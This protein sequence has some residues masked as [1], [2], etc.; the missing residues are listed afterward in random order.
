MTVVSEQ[1]RNWMSPVWDARSSLE[2]LRDHLSVVLVSLEDIGDPALVSRLS[3]SRSALE[4][5]CVELAT[6]TLALA[7]VG[8]TSS[9]KST[10]INA[11]LGTRLAPMNVDEMSAGMLRIEH[12]ER[13]SLAATPG[14]P[15]LEF[16]RDPKAIYHRLYEEMISHIERREAKQSVTP[17]SFVVTGPLFPMNPKH[18]FAHRLSGDV[19]LRVFDLPGLRTINDEEN[20]RVIKGQIRRAFAVVV[21]NMIQLFA[22]EQREQILDELRETVRDLGNDTSTI[23]FVA[24]QADRLTHG[25]LENQSLADRLNIEAANIAEKLD[26]NPGSVELL[27]FSALNYY[28]AA[29]L[30]R[31][32]DAGNDAAARQL[33]EPFVRDFNF[34]YARMSLDDAE[35]KELRALVREVEDDL[36][37]SSS[38]TSLAD[39]NRLATLSL[40]A[41]G[42]ARFWYELCLRIAQNGVELI[43]YPTANIPLKQ[44]SSSLRDAIQYAKTRQST[45]R[46]E[47]EATRQQMNTLSET[48]SRRLGEH[49]ASLKSGLDRLLGLLKLVSNDNISRG[50]IYDVLSELGISEETYEYLAKARNLLLNLRV[51]L[52]SMLLEPLLD[53]LKKK[54]KLGDL[55]SRLL[56]AG[57]SNELVS[58]VIDAYETVK[59]VGYPEY[60]EHGMEFR[61]ETGVQDPEIEKVRRIR[62]SLAALFLALRKAMTQFSERHLRRESDLVA[63][64]IAGWLSTQGS[65]VWAQVLSDLSG[66]VSVDLPSE[67]QCTVPGGSVIEVPEQVITI[68]SVGLDSEETVQEHAGTT[69]EDPEASCFKGKEVEVFKD[70]TYTTYRIPNAESMVSD[71]DQGVR[72]ASADFWDRF[73]NW[74]TGTVDAMGNDMEAEV[75]NYAE[76]VKRAV[77]A[78][79]REL[80][81]ETSAEVAQWVSVEEE[82]VSGLALADAAKKAVGFR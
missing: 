55:R 38:T 1:Q 77:S 31:E 51:K 20:L 25:D 64:D 72:N 56:K 60:A 48:T 19:T 71:L 58:G 65:T 5:A 7:S 26:I 73:H 66:A 45:S 11:L 50:E 52:E 46:E 4:A 10:F 23:I 67:L 16:L 59:D 63:K 80:E 54:T 53:A 21:V 81:L 12:G 49:R 24:N 76:T 43:V 15:G 34:W 36:D 62:A 57:I 27:P 2:E 17:P 78:R 29:E 9:G 33:C 68:P 13:W 39:L 8:T 18:D 70:V 35:A 82:L 61:Y 44:C 6:P 28:R 79:I 32:T 14:L 40:K 37:D 42:H 22:S 69:N 3:E 74:L 47:L 41:S 30:W 75:N